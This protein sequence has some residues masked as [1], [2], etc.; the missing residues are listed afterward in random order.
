MDI[1]THSPGHT[2]PGTYVCKNAMNPNQFMHQ[3]QILEGF[4][5]SDGLPRPYIAGGWCWK[6]FQHHPSQHQV[7]LWT[8]DSVRRSSN[9][10]HWLCIVSEDLLTPSKILF[11]CINWFGFKVFQDLRTCPLDIPPIYPPP[12]HTQPTPIWTYPL[13]LVTPGG[14]HWGQLCN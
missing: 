2:H 14:H 4:P 10:I 8:V 11:W 1:P 9:T 3:N 7:R 6:T 13:L 5:I 12:G